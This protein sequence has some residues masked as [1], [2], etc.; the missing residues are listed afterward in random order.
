M[1]G[2]ERI[3]LI[4]EEIR[5][6]SLLEA[7]ENRDGIN[8]MNEE[9]KKR[10]YNRTMGKIQNIKIRGDILEEEKE[11]K[12]ES[13][14]DKKPWVVAFSA[15]FTIVLAACAVT[16]HYSDVF[17]RY[18]QPADEKTEVSG[19]MILAEETKDDVTV[20]LKE[21][22]GDAYG[23]YIY[24]QIEKKGLTAQQIPVA[25]DISIDGI[26]DSYTVMDP[27]LGGI[28]GDTADYMIGI[29]TSQDIQGKKCKFHLKDPGY[30]DALDQYV[31]FVEHEF[32]FDFSIDYVDMPEEIEV[33]KEIEIYGGTAVF[34]KVS[35]SPLSVTVFLTEKE[36]F[37]TYAS[38][39]PEGKAVNDELT[40]RFLDGSIR[41]SYRL[42]DDYDIFHDVT[43][44]SMGLHK[45]VSM[46]E[47]EN[48]TF[49]GVTIP[50]NNNPDAQEELSYQNK[51]M[52]I[53]VEMPKELFD[54]ITPSD[55]EDFLEMVE[56]KEGKDLTTTEVK[57][58]KIDFTGKKDGKEKVLF[59]V[60]RLSGI[61]HEALEDYDPMMHYLEGRGDYIY[62]LKYSE[63]GDETEIEEFADVMNQ[64][65][66]KIKERI[67]IIPYESG[68]VSGSGIV[69]VQTLKVRTSASMEA[70][71]K[72]L[73]PEG[74]KVELLGKEG[75]FY[76]ISYFNGK[77]REKG[78][79][80]K[81]YLDAT[82]KNR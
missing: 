5:G 6:D 56:N 17:Q 10:I 22:I 64:Y 37:K 25:A 11:W 47:I 18:F 34:D 16:Y 2:K 40:V 67:H 60:Y 51:E 23:C 71:T 82:E 1:E 44:I 24:Y 36:P 59:S 31:P 12:K 9:E 29:R 81:K 72:A 68:T 20:R 38:E 75:D 70:D 13:R 35:I 69:N 33:G 46:K 78:Y 50:I 32:E 30:Y 41:D 66:S 63:L 8:D 19:V 4:L 21:V 27:F 48:I 54:M 26:S 7:P 45:I 65:V 73:L 42:M 61:S 52:G 15:V 79:V 58:K 49:A 57:G 39:L 77:D 76:Y 28:D 14:R 74:E 43:V 62:T 53:R 80:M 55:V 3:D